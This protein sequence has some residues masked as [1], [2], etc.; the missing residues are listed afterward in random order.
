[1]TVHS[2]IRFINVPAAADFALSASAEFL[3]KC[4][5]ELCLPVADRLIGEHD[6]ADQKHLSQISQTEFVPEPPKDHERDHVARMLRP[7]QQATAAF[8][9]LLRAVET[10]EPTII[11]RG[12]LRPLLDRGRSA[13]RAT[14]VTSL[15]HAGDPSPTS[16]GRQSPGLVADR[17]QPISS[18]TAPVAVI[19][20][21]LEAAAVTTSRAKRSRSDA[22]TIP[23]FVY[24][25]SVAAC[26]TNATNGRLQAAW[27][28]RAGASARYC[29]YASG[30]GLATT[31]ACS[32]AANT[33]H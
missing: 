24:P 4:G 31:S 15:P 29:G 16:R 6:A 26:R 21:P 1:M 13:F 28:R 33:G 8:V 10:T 27:W 7:V 14:H 11:L 32:V 30:V 2:N 22:T 25:A 5:G 17:A 9:E 3:R 12:A 18:T 20:E 19:D 23:A